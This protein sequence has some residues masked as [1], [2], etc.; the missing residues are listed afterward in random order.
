MWTAKTLISLDGCP[1]WSKSSLGAHAILLVLSWSGS[2]VSWSRTKPVKWS[3]H[4]AKTQ[5]SLGN[6][7]PSLVRVFFG[8]WLS[9]ERSK[10]WSDCN[11]WHADPSLRWVHRSFCWFVVL[12]VH[13]WATSWETYLSHI[14]NNRK[15]ITIVQLS[16]ASAQSDQHLCL[17]SR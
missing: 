6:Q 12:A 7:P 4:P 5:I 8:S 16:L 1:G 13:I 17:L 9:L 10:E 3:V 11:D 15:K 2:V 14:E